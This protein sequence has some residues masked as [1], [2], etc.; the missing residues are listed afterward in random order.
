MQMRGA[1]ASSIS[2]CVALGKR[3]ASLSLSFFTD[4]MGVTIESMTSTTC[5]D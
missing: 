1:L 5:E 3:L 4:K 2:R